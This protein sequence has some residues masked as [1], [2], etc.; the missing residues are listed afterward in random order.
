MKLRIW[1]IIP[2]FYKQAY[3][4]CVKGC[5]C[6]KVISI[7]DVLGAISDERSLLLFR[8]IARFSFNSE[9]S[10]EILISTLHLKSKQYYSR[11]SQLVKADL[12]IR[13]HG[14]YFLTSFG[15][16]VYDAQTTIE[17][18]L[19]NYW[20]LKAI[21]RLEKSEHIPQEEYNE[22]IHLLIDNEGIKEK[23]IIEKHP[24]T[25]KV[26]P[27]RSFNETSLLSKIDM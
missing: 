10:S 13:R 19:A 12:V 20:K 15:K 2:T 18:A 16:L 26:F 21:D 1:L 24:I 17:K 7:I 27:D 25:H 23:I 9:S 8:T 11:M 22:I 14:K 5:S 4:V 6:T 3:S